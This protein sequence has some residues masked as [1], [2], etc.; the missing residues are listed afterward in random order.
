MEIEQSA[1]WREVQQIMEDGAKPVHELFTAQIFVGESAEPIIPSIVL[2]IDFNNNYL[3]NY[4]EDVQVTLAI[5][6]GTY[7]KR[8]YPFQKSIDILLVSR[9]VGEISDAQ[10]LERK[11]RSER[12]TAT[13]IDTGN[14]IIEMSSR[15]T[16]SEEVLN[17]TD[18]YTVTFQLVNKSL[19][20]I[21]M[22]TV[23]GNYHNVKGEDVVKMW[24]TKGSQSVKV[25]QNRLLKG[26]D[27]IPASN[28][29]VREHVIIPQGTKL[30]DLP[31]HVHFK[32]GGL[33]SS[34][35]GYFLA[36]DYWFVYP[37]FDTTR[38]NEEGKTLTIINI[39]ANRLPGIERTYREDGDNLVILSTGQ[40]KFRDI[41]N[42]EQLNAGNGVRFA[43]A[44]QLIDNFAA[45]GDNK[46]IASRGATN[47][48]F[49]G[50][51][52]ANGQNLVV[53]SQ[54]PINA[55]PFVEYSALARR[56]G[57]MISLVWENS[58]RQMLHPGMPVRI[59]YLDDD[60]IKTLYGTLMH[61]HAYVETRAPGLTARRHFTNTMLGVFVKPL[62]EE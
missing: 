12:Y 40:V 23:G 31:H 16:P 38:F 32:C 46:A 14:P 26:V 48:E 10:D 44:D 29:K 4:A 27:M 3:D 42:A 30:V 5:G 25:D 49:I 37:C 1:L 28:Q 9:P 50:Q 58:N 13:L 17:L 35:L 6:A 41:S 33:Y 24:L 45:S 39:P 56:Q 62:S 57:S 59:M 2:S 22:V 8:I 36:G 55:N 20:K 61:N 52:R 19:E 47:S 43:D 11:S 7:A 54:R 18:L 21:R 15:N 53:M 51:E 34:G 60:V